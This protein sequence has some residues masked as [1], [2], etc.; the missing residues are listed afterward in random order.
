M[1]GNFFSISDLLTTNES[2]KAK[3]NQNLEKEIYRLLT[4]MPSDERE[5]VIDL[6]L[7]CLL[8][9]NYHFQ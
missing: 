3:G 6:P 4:G 9:M 7:W 8:E 2:V 5:T 1:T